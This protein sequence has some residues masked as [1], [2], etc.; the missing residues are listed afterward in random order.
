[1]QET[2]LAEFECQ[3][4]PLPSDEEWRFTP[5]GPIAET[6]FAAPS[7][8]ATIAPDHPAIQRLRD[9][10]GVR[11]VLVNGEY[12]PEL[13]RTVEMPPSVQVLRLRQ[14]ME[15]YP[16]LVKLYLGRLA[17]GAPSL[18]ALNFALMQDGLFL[19]LRAGTVLSDPVHILHLSV[20]AETPQVVSP[21]HLVVLEPSASAT[22]LESYLP[23]YEGEYWTNVVTEVA[24]HDNASLQHY[25]LQH[26]SAASYHTGRTAVHVGRDARYISHSV[27]IGAAIGRHDFGVVL[28]G[29]GG[30]CTLNG[31]YVG[32]DRQLIDNHT[33][34]DHTAPHCES[35]ETYKGILDDR[36]HGVF[37]GKVYVR[38]DAQKTDA[39]QSNH[40]LL[41]SDAARIDTKP[42]LEIFA[43]DVRCTHGAT[44]G[45][46]DADALFY[47]RT[48]GIALE[49]A[50]SILVH[51]FASEIVE[52]MELEPV[53]AEL[54]AV[55]LRSL[56]KPSSI[57]AG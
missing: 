51:A 20:P 8:D 56:P 26:E 44:V 1:M 22:V 45:Q 40:A 24:L 53:R 9:L 42:Q 17:I 13:S 54:E 57:L 33:T 5:I 46:L 23:A 25:R 29:E 32:K 36:S 15:E 38:Q 37:N 19:R 43:D 10:Q 55:L 47:L 50:R 31:L 49:D 35:H 30:Y 16:E 28:K 39:K 14:A 27:Q 2:A 18:T 12:R 52:R 41:L 34:I 21:R 6:L 4:F 7:R 11:L 3:G 48:R